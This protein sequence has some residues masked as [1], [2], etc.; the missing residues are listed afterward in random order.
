ME[1]FNHVADETMTTIDGAL[2][3]KK[4]T[5]SSRVLDVEEHELYSACIQSLKKLV[6]V[7]DEQEEEHPDTLPF[8]RK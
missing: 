1:H 4:I 6:A 5:H 8:R 7:D 2:G 3:S